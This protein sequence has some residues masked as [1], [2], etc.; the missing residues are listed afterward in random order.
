[1]VRPWSSLT[2]CR[3]PCAGVVGAWAV[4][5]SAPSPS[6]S[7]P[8]YHSYLLLTVQGETKVLETG[9]ELQEVTDRVDYVVNA[10]TLAAGSMMGSQ[11]VVQV[12]T[13]P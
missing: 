11:R 9:E 3:Q 7:A 5:Y 1:M 8:A 2:P 10:P 6:P 4:H 13:K 12:T